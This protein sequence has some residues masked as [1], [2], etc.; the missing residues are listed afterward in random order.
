LRARSFSGNPSRKVIPRK[1]TTIKSAA[2]AL[3]IAGVAQASAFE[4][5]MQEKMACRTD[6]GTPCSQIIGKAAADPRGRMFSGS[7]GEAKSMIR[8]S[9]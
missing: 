5:S 8:Q 3:L 7:R 1:S 4:A 9:V 2:I 6:A